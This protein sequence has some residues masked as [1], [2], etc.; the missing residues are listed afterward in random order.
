M[1][2]L[3]KSAV[4]YLSV[5]VASVMLGGFGNYLAPLA[6]DDG[7]S[8]KGQTLGIVIPILLFPIAFVLWLVY[9]GHVATSPWLKWFL[10]G[11]IFAWFVHFALTRFHGDMYVH[12]V[13]LFIP[14]ILMV[15]F[16][17]PNSEEAWSALIVLAWFAVGAL[18]LTRVLELTGVIPQW[19]YPTPDQ[20]LWEREHYWLPF[21]GH[22]DVASRWPGPF[23]FNS[24]TGFVSVVI[25]VIG[26]A[27]WRKFSSPVF[28]TFGVLGILL[29]GGRGVYL[30]LVAGVL[31]LVLFSHWSFLTKVPT[32]VRLALLALAVCFLGYKFAASATA[33]TGRIGDDG[34]WNSF[35]DLWRGSPLTGVGLSGIW[36]APGRAGEAMDAHSVFVQ[37]LAQFGVLGFVAINS[38]LAIGLVACLFSAARK[39]QGPLAIVTVYLVAGATDLL[40]SSWELH[41]LHT[42]LVIL[43]ITSAATW[44]KPSQQSISRSAFAS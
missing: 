15:L 1:E 7:I 30:S 31:V 37:E 10:G 16:K 28:I 36:N 41:S 44:L 35:L 21:A 33:T 23:G 40:H 26:L 38:V 18:V 34:I 3:R 27:R 9:N 14:I 20:A 29:T 13:W 42:L 24:K 11:L 2:F 22:F 19:F 25:V 5:L 6:F 39:W 8:I 17:A 43:A 12:T 32:A 4:P